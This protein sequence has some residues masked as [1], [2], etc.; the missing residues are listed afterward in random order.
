M[1]PTTSESTQRKGSKNKTLAAAYTQGKT[2][3][4]LAWLNQALQKAGIQ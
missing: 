2:P 3:K 1:K 4:S